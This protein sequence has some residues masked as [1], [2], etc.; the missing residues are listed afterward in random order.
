MIREINFV[1]MF[2]KL[3]KLKE[4]NDEKLNEF[5]VKMK[6]KVSINDLFSFEKMMVD[7]LD[8]I[9]GDNEKGKAEKIETKNALVFL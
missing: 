8:F 5:T 4:E 7:K 2:E 6:K 1:E 3:K 9:L